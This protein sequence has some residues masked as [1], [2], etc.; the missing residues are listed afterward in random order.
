MG[1]V[2]D[3]LTGVEGPDGAAL[4]HVYAIALDVS[5]EAGEGLSYGMPALLLHGKG[6]ASALRAKDHL[7]VFP[8]SGRVL[9]ALGDRLEGFDWSKG[10]LR[11]SAAHPVPDEVLRAIFTARRAEIE[12]TV[13]PRG[14]GI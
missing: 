11:F 3:Y 6:Y 1:E 12:S 9:A 5:P 7:S 10:T 4:S 2:T 8:F 13:K 14:K